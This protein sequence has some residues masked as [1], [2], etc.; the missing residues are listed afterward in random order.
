MEEPKICIVRNYALNITA[1][2]DK[3]QPDKENVL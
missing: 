3:C 1:F 2:K